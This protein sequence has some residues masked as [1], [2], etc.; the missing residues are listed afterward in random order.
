MLREKK[1]SWVLGAIVLVALFVLP[2]IIPRFWVSLVTEILIVGL[3]GMSV[4]LLLGYG[5]CLS[6]GHAAFYATGAY[7][8]AILVERT[9]IPEFLVLIIAPLIATVIGAIVGL[10]VA[11]LYG[12]Y[13]AIMTCAFSMLIWSIIRKWTSLTMGENGI[14]GVE[15]SEMLTGINNVY[16]FTL[17]IV[18]LSLAALW[19]IIN[20]PFGWT[21]RAI[22]ENPTRSAF[23]SID[24]IKHRYL[25]FV[26]SSFFCGIAGALYVVYSHSA[27][28]DYSYWVKSAD[29][30][31]VCVL[32]GMSLYL[33]PMAGS[34][35][36][37]LLQ[38]LITSVTLYWLLI[39]GIIICVVVLLMPDGVLG[40]LEKLKAYTFRRMPHHS[41]ENSS[42]KQRD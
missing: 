12:F 20:S 23:T 25:A 13:F 17:I 21:L 27:F 18:L 8:T 19:I 3:A 29:L 33:G 32:G 1:V 7:A 41:S 31:I 26:M 34:A 14:T 5:G 6:F 15:F 40:K 37:V 10:L 28:P 4:N 9:V 22:R 35:I 36:F 38:T 42:S 24:V 30:V 2:V 39:M 11:R 16:Y